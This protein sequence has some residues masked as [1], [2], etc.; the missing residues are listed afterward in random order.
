MH[1]YIYIYRER[2][3]ER[4]R[5]GERVR[6]GERETFI[7]VYIYICV[8]VIIVFTKQKQKSNNK[9]DARKSSIGQPNRA[10]FGPI[11]ESSVSSELFMLSKITILYYKKN[12]VGSQEGVSLVLFVSRT[13]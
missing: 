8:G 1:I 12:C 2:E 10:C 13:V 6:E 11:G 7:Y 9:R 5:A 4:E 3:R